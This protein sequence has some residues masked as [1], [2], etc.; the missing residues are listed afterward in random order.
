[1]NKSLSRNESIVLANIYKNKQIYI[2]YKYTNSLFFNCNTASNTSRLICERVSEQARMAVLG[3]TNPSLCGQFNLGISAT[4]MNRICAIVNRA[5]LA[6]INAFN[7]CCFGN[8][9]STPAS[10]PKPRPDCN[11][12]NEANC[13][14]AGG[15]I[16][17][18][19]CRGITI[20]TTTCNGQTL[21]C[22]R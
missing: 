1:L 10:T 18:S 21:R 6:A 11:A 14:S 9:Q 8:N 2:T 19:S 12:T 16:T 22:C 7:N 3:N 13:R 4:T 5:N 15:T 20:F 17:T